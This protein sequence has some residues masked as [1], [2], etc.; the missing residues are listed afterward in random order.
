[1]SQFYAPEAINRIVARNAFLFE[2]R[3]R[4][5]ALDVRTRLEALDWTSLNE[6]ATRPICR[7]LSRI[8]SSNRQAVFPNLQPEDRT[9]AIYIRPPATDGRPLVLVV[10][11]FHVLP[12]CH[13]GAR[14]SSR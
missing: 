14:A 9:N 6:L 5:E 13:G 8:R 11:P 2:L 7:E 3:N 4:P 1:V 12:P 10:S